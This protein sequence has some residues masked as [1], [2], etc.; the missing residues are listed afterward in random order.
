MKNIT[1]SS[2][3]FAIAAAIA[4]P[5]PAAAQALSDGDYERCAV[6][7]HNDDFAGYDSVCL[8]R[9]RAALRHYRARDRESYSVYVHYCP[10]WANGGEGYHAT[11]YDD[12]RPPAYAGNFDSTENGRPCVPNPSYYSRGYY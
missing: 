8:E 5:C 10:S 2:I 3:A 6:Y 9:R 1:A 4:A 12:G 7:D 11:W